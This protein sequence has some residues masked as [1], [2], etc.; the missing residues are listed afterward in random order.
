MWCVT[1]VG[2]GF[3]GGLASCWAV[4][5]LK[6]K[7]RISWDA[8]SVETPERGDLFAGHRVLQQFSSQAVFL[9]TSI[10]CWLWVQ[11][12]YSLLACHS[13]GGS[14]HHS[15]WLLWITISVSHHLC[16]MVLLEDSY[17]CGK[18]GLGVQDL[19]DTSRFLVLNAFF[20][21]RDTQ[22]YQT[23]QYWCFSKSETLQLR[24]R[25]CICFSWCLPG[26]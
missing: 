6:C 2:Q 21:P 20:S 24:I 5:P 26:S 16:H 25:I 11:A 13:W 8:V 12:H 1:P 3:Q 15:G 9:G 18:W 7:C 4:M 17:G 14:S 19:W 10:S 23:W 22:P